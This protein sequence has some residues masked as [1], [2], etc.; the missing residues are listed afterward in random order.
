VVR[1]PIAPVCRVGVPC[2]APA[3]HATLYFSRSG[4]TVG[5]T[6]NA[7]GYYRIRLPNGLY[8][9]KTKRQ[10]VGGGLEPRTVRVVAGRDKRADFQ[11]DTGIR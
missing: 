7:N 4:R 1:G 5:T 11:I 8:A 9:V 3:A 6:T 10:S 2:T